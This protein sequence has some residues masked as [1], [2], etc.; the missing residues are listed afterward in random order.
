MTFNF[1]GISMAYSLS[2]THFDQDGNERLVTT[3]E[4]AHRAYLGPFLNGL[5][6]T[7]R[8]L[9]LGD[10]ENPPYRLALELRDSAPIPN[11]QAPGL[12]YGYNYELILQHET[13]TGE[14]TQ[15]VSITG[16]HRLCLEASERGLDVELTKLPELPN[17]PVRLHLALREY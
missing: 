17:L 16:A 10:G 7:L 15:A 12:R 2:I 5:D 13:S 6:V 14:I 11:P 4:S 9:P 8:E 3:A 1:K